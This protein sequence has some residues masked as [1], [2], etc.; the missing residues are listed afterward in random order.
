MITVSGV[1]VAVRSA[2]VSQGFVFFG[3][4]YSMSFLLI[5]LVEISVFTALMLAGL[6]MRKPPEI[7]RAMKL[8]ASLSLLL[9]A[10]TRIPSLVAL[11]GRHESRMV[12]FGPVFCSGVAVCYG[13]H[14]CTVA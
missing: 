3:M 7:H 5:M 2:Q 4:N 13:A 8:D 14:D 6:A 12:F 1:L 11:F 10:T 9:G